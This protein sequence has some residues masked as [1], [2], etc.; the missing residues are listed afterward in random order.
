MLPHPLAVPAK[1]YLDITARCNLSCRYCYHFDSAAAVPEDLPTAE[2]LKFFAELNR[3]GVM[4]VN[5][6][7][8]EPLMRP[9]IMELL[10]AF[11]QTR[12]RFDLVTNGSLLKADMAE[13]I[14]ALRRCNVVQISLDGPEEMHDAARGKGAWQAAIEAINILKYYRIP[15]AVRTTIGH[16]NS[17]GLM[18]TA[19]LIFDRLQLPNFTTNCVAIQGLCH[20]NAAGLELTVPELFSSIEEH[21][22]VLARYPGRLLSSTG[23]WGLYLKWQKLYEAWQH[24][25]RRGSYSGC[26]GGC[27]AVYKQM[28][29]R[30]DGAMIPC[31]QMPDFPMGR[32][33]QDELLTIWRQSQILERLRRRRKISLRNFPE[34]ADCQYCDYCFGGCPAN[35]VIDLQTM[36]RRVCRYCFK[37]VAAYFHCL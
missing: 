34:C 10:G 30:A 15:I 25:T 4:N 35:S 9:D 33:N 37:D 20:K 8:G 27:A 36:E 12:L 28:G 18:A 17:G 7:G 29:V 13:K 3:I 11:S 21:K 16:H 6:S 32:I 22:A 5:I 24:K 26:L 31:V 14:A 2:W 1:I 23:P 19:E